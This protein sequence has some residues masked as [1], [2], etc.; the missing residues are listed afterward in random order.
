MAVYRL[1]LFH[2]VLACLA[3]LILGTGLG[4]SLSRLQA[5]K[6][7][8]SSALITPRPTPQ[9]TPE[10]L[11]EP[12]PTEGKIVVT[13]YFD[14][15][16]FNPNAASCSAVFP[17]K[18]Q[19][20]VTN[21][22]LRAAL[23][24]LFMGPTDQEKV[25]GYRSVFSDTTKDLLKSLNVK[26][27]TV[28]LDFNRPSALEVVKS[29]ANS[30]CGHAQFLSSIEMTSKGFV[31]IKQVDEKNFTIGGSRSAYQGLLGL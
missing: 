30:S 25:F 19:L 4:F 20:P 22:P 13:V 15:L 29:G 7:L 5:A 18:R 1:P 11:P 12:T 28:Y 3:F 16:L 23:D 24:Q 17:V 8:P 26:N 9:P 14:N 2:C 21:I 10:G 27:G 31:G 6:T